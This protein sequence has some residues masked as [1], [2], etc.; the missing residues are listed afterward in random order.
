LP[1]FGQFLE[2]Q[3][4]LVAVG[5]GPVMQVDHGLHLSCVFD[6][7]KRDHESKTFSCL[8]IRK[9]F[10]IDIGKRGGGSVQMGLVSHQHARQR[11][12]T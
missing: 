2:Q 5:R 6:A 8:E 1:E 4:H 9:R 11:G 7:R 3:R 12:R 10:H